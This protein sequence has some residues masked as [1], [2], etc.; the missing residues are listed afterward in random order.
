M[1]LKLVTK[2]NYYVTVTIERTIHRRVHLSM[3]RVFT[4]KTRDTS[5]KM[6]KKA[7]EEKICASTFNIVAETNEI[8]KN[9]YDIL[10]IYH[11]NYKPISTYQIQYLRV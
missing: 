10:A 6:S 11:L 8:D 1:Y 4:S 5:K 7:P 9:S 2:L 3:K